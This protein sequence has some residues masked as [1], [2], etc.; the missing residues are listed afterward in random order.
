MIRINNYLTTV[1][2]TLNNI[3]ELS[4]TLESLCVLTWQ[5]KEI[6]IIDSDFT[7]KNKMREIKR[8]EYLAE[9]VFCESKL[10]D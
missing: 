10:S 7:E 6:I 3:E 1:S 5:P 4:R 2:V 8:E 9:D